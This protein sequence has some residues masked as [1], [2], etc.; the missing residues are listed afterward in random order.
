MAKKRFES[1]LDKEWIGM[2]VKLPLE[3]RKLE[4]QHCD[5]NSLA[6]AMS[7]Q[8]NWQAER[9]AEA[10]SPSTSR[11]FIKVVKIYKGELPFPKNKRIRKRVLVLN[12]MRLALSIL[13]VVI[14][15]ALIFVLNVYFPS[16]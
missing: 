3:R 1:E 15:V 9:I 6:K 16:N 7:E 10:L 13:S 8:P 4:L 2:L 11:E 12:K 5:L 14:L